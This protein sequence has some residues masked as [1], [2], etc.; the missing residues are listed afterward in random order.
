MSRSTNQRTQVYTIVKESV[1]HPSAEEVYFQ[2][3]TAI[4]NISLG[5]VYRN[6]KLLAQE[7]LIRE[8]HFGSGPSRYD[9]ML[10]AHEHFICT[11]CNK[12]VDITPTITRPNLG[13]KVVT[14][15]RLDYFGTCEA[16]S[17]R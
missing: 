8:I 17:A 3:K 7:G 12:V 13:G 16:C 6:L 10:E 9:G 2:A 11:N 5:T 1:A 4:P 14:G 15:Y